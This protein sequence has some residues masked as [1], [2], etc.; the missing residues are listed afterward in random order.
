MQRPLKDSVV[1]D[2]P[3]RAGVRSMDQV[4]YGELMQKSGTARLSD[5]EANEVGRL[6]ARKRGET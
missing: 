4:R 6:M 1:A 2:P 3:I 5:A